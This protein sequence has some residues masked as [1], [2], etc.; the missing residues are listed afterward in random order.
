MCCW[1]QEDNTSILTDTNHQRK[2]LLHSPY[3]IDGNFFPSLDELP[4][5]AVKQVKL[6]I[7]RQQIAD[8]E[9]WEECECVGGLD[10]AIGIGRKILSLN[11]HTESKSNN[12]I[13]ITMTS[14]H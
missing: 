13:I 8:G 10:E 9:G 4:D 14:Q 2:S 7:T 3:W 1:Y 6:D 11:V 5:F 12:N